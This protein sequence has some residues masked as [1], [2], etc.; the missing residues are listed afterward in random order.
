MKKILGNISGII[1]YFGTI[2]IVKADTAKILDSVN[3]Y[4]LTAYDW[5][6]FVHYLIGIVLFTAGFFLAKIMENKNAS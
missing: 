2:S 4:P 6:K 5:E 3:S 1:L